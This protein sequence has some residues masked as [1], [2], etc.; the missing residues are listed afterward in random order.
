MVLGN[1]FAGQRWRHRHREQTY[2]HGQ[3]EEVE[4]EMNGESSMEACTLP[5][6]K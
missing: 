2:G 1:L 4:G 3:R 5:C 6:V